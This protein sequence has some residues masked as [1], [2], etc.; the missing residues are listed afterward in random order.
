MAIQAS[1]GFSY[2]QPTEA[3]RQE[4]MP[5][6]NQRPISLL[7]LSTL[8]EPWMMFLQP[9]LAPLQRGP[10]SVSLQTAVNDKSVVK[11]QRHRSPHGPFVH[12]TCQEDFMDPLDCQLQHLSRGKC[13]HSYCTSPPA[14]ST[15]PRA[16]SGPPPGG[17]GGG[18]VHCY[19][20]HGALAAP[21]P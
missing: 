12:V 18:G 11:T 20:R 1:S 17:G 8:S 14:T 2:T 6:L 3:G 19:V 5:S 9:P 16:P 7:A 10:S 13:Q 21:L 15:L 4:V